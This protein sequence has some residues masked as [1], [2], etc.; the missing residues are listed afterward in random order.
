MSLQTDLQAAVDKASA[1]SAKLHGVVHGDSTSTVET[2]NGPVKTVAKAIAY[3]EADIDASRA[4]LDQKV[5]DAAVNT[6]ILSAFTAK[7]RSRPISLG[8]TAE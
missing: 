8:T 5:S 2:E 6:E 4:E 3:I 7:A 1:A